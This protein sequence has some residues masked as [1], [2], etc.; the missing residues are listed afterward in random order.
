[1]QVEHAAQKEMIS[2]AAFSRR[3]IAAA[4]RNPPKATD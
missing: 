1:M 4:V 3:A 2:F